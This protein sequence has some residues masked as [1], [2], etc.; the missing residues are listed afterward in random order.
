MNV[1]YS[2]AGRRHFDDCRTL[3]GKQRAGNSSH[4]AGLAAECALKAVLE[5]LGI[6][7]LDTRGVPAD[8]KH[9]KHI[10]KIWDEFQAAL[11]GRAAVMYTLRGAN[12]FDDWKIEHRYE[13]DSTIDQATAEKHCL[14]AHTAMLLLER[15]R[16]EGDVR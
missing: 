13:A 14:G 10:D 12:P 11:S 6:L 16:I 5:G 8:P 7:T 2:Q 9:K 4:L 1:N 15:A 3:S